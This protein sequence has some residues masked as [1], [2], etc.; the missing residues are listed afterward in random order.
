LIALARLAEQNWFRR[1]WQVYW[2]ILFALTHIRQPGWPAW[3]PPAPSDKTM[4]V[5]FFFVLAWVGWLVLTSK[6]NRRAWRPIE[7]FSIVALYGACDE[8]T[9]P[10]FG[11]ACAILDWVADCAGAILAIGCVEV[12]RLWRRTVRQTRRTATGR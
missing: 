12:F 2:V 1:L 10:M 4:H 3:A 6:G 7:W 11:R 8:V 5:C 9:Q